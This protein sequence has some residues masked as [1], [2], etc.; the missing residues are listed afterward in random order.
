MQ[1]STNFSAQE[2]DELEQ[3]ILQ[4]P[5]GQAFL[6][7]HAHRHKVI[8]NDVV[9]RALDDFRGLL[10]GQDSKSPIEILRAELQSMGT[11]IDHARQDIADIKP[12]DSTNNRIMAATGE[13]DAI[14]TAAERAT[15]EILA[16]A[17]QIQDI[18]DKLREAGADQDL[19]DSIVDK[20]TD[21]FMACSFQDITG[22]RTTKVVNVLQYLEQRVAAMAEIWSSD[23]DK[24]G[25][26]T[27]AIGETRPDADLLEGP[28]LEGQGIDQN[29]VD[30]LLNA[31]AT[32]AGE[33]PTARAGVAATDSLQEIVAYALSE[34]TAPDGDEI[35]IASG[36]AGVVKKMPE[37][38]SQN[39]IDAMFD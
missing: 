24:S 4:R 39:D 35:S 31:G 23:A 32:E 34:A 29:D 37:D 15:N 33:V 21:I 2:Y 18:S 8:G 7:E 10:A 26:A 6:R 9:I 25:N 1:E 17:E 13:L 36:P 3:A 16:A 22:Q 38:Q 27:A 19:C 28:Q 12:K 11:A 14:V 20:A 5:R 30:E